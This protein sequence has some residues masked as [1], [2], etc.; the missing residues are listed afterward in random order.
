M[1]LRQPR[2]FLLPA[3]V[4]RPGALELLKSLELYRV[5]V[6]IVSAGLSDIIEEFLRQHGAPSPPPS[7]HHPT[8][9][10]AAT[11]AAAATGATTTFSSTFSASPPQQAR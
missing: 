1:E 11:T 2:A 8:T 5:P 6:L 4:P 3:Q 9:S 10:T 7:Q